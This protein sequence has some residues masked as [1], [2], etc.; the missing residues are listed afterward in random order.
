M[1]WESLAE[2]EKELLADDVAPAEA[3]AKLPEWAKTQDDMKALTIWD[4][5]P[6]IDWSK[7]AEMVTEWFTTAIQKLGE[8]SDVDLVGIHLG[9]AP[10]I[11][12]VD[13]YKFSGGQEKID[14]LIEMLQAEDDEEWVDEIDWD[15][16]AELSYKKTEKLPSGLWKWYMDATESDDS[17]EFMDSECVYAMWD[18][19]AIL[20]VAHVLRH[21]GLDFAAI[22]GDRT[23]IP[24]AMGY[25]NSAQ[26]SGALTPLGWLEP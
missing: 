25:E 8:A 16:V 6:Q 24:I 23:K 9:D 1:D 20:T 4:E 21:G 5:F 11:F 10:E 18:V 15:E 22:V 17:S 13:G 2:F 3:M 14:D 12:G 19:L 26:Y 7:D